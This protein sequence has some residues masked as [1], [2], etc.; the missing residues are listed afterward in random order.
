VSKADLH[1][2]VIAYLEESQPVQDILGAS[3]GV[4]PVALAQER[5]DLDPRLSVGVSRTGSTRN[6]R[7]VETEYEVRVIVD[8][9]DD[10]V[11]T[12]GDGS[13]LELEELQDAVA[14]TLEEHRDDR[15]A[16]GVSNEEEVAWSDS[17]NRHLGVVAIS[18]SEDDVHDNVNRV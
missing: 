5:D 8:A 7:R 2:D 18:Y 11:G 6:N 15:G 4:I 1:A 9:T 10:W 17:V 16:G 14:D 13:V 3:G 12:G